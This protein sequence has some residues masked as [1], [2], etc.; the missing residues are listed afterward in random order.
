[1]FIKNNVTDLKTANTLLFFMKAKEHFSKNKIFQAL[2][3]Y[4]SDIPIL[5][6]YLRIGTCQM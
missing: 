5:G 4:R 3:C 1:M 2:K 6:I